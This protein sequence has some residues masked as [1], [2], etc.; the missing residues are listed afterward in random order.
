[1]KP[2]P[3]A[4]AAAPKRGPANLTDDTARPTAD[5]EAAARVLG[6]AVEGLQAMAK[7]LDGDFR[8]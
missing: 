5:H 7:T 1:M 4:T 3:H 8:R 2:I 6:L